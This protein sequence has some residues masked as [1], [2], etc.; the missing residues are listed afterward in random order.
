MPPSFNEFLFV[1]SIGASGGLLVAWNSQLLV[2]S[3]R[4]ISGSAIAVDLISKIDGSEWTVLNVYGPCT[5][6]GKKEFTDYLKSITIPDNE[7]WIIMGDFNLYRTSEN[8]NREGANIGDM[9]LFNSMISHM[10]LTE[11]PLHGKRFT[12]SNMQQPPLLEK[13]DWVF[14]NNSWTL[15]YPETSCS[16]LSMEVS[17]HWPL[18]VTISTD[19]PKVAIF[20][21]ENF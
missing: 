9:F 8:R 11:I 15:T 4:L 3:T 1:P 18:V 21:F 2:G 12:W 14:T 5:D 13:L 17:D 19:V 6:E 20:R 16:A 10:E 7:E